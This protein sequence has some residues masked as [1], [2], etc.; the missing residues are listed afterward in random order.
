MKGELEGMMG[1]LADEVWAEIL[2]LPY[3]LTLLRLNEDSY[4]HGRGS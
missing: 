2:E 4:I 1:G 3:L